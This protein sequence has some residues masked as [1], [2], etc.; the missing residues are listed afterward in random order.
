M[1]AADHA[2]VS[3][4]LFAFRHRRETGPRFKSFRDLKSAEQKA[5]GGFNTSELDA[6]LNVRACVCE[7]P[8][9]A[10]LFVAFAEM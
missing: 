3:F 8:R 9:M 5:K 4:A 7:C 2:P 10:I 1:Y 6:L